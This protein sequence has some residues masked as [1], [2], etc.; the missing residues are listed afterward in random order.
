MRN[1]T[2]KLG[3]RRIGVLEN[4]TGGIGLARRLGPAEDGLAVRH[5]G[6]LEPWPGWAVWE[7]ECEASGGVWV[8]GKVLW[9]AEVVCKRHKPG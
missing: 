9:L 1:S 6:K 8:V 3:G 7:V 2:A 4:D 5:E